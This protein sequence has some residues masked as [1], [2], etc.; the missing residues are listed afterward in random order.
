[1]RYIQK[2][3][4]PKSLTKY[5]KNKNAYFDGYKE[6]DDIR[7][8]LLKE[9]GYLCG[10]CMCR[11]QGAKN[12][13]IEHLTPQSTLDEK[14]ALNYKIMMGVC[15][16]NEKKGHASKCLTCDAHRGNEPLKVTPYN[17]HCIELIKYKS[18][19]RIYSE[20][21]EI[22]KDLDVTLNLNYD[23]TGAYLMKNRREVLN[24]CKRKLSKLQEEGNW[25]NALL[26]RILKEY[27]EPDSEGKLKPY[28]GIAV[29]YLKKRLKK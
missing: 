13:K 26:K 24:A 22:L 7:E 29:W 16:G 28:S 18:N 9:Q 19:G 8:S 14:A 17:P 21:A 6:K 25:N 5:K 10:Y 20:D 3:E 4:E 1:M 11:I 15:H 2:K 23:G 12:T 27:E